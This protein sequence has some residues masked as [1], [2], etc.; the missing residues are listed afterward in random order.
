MY[1]WAG[2][3]PLTWPHVCMITNVGVTFDLC[4]T[5]TVR[6]WDDQVWGFKPTTLSCYLKDRHL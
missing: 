1:P 2:K 5:F 3:G 6:A 4:L